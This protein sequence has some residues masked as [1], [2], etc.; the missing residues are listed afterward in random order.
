MLTH[1]LSCMVQS[2]TPM[3]SGHSSP[4][5]A[6]IQPKNT[7]CCPS[8]LSAS[9]NDYP[10]KQQEG[11]ALAM[12]LSDQKW[13]RNCLESGLKCTVWRMVEA[14]VSAIGE[15]PSKNS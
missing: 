11:L 8:P 15:R 5:D 4:S 12:I 10:P 3:A 2:I 9:P 7:Q 14:A 1:S 13:V 6:S